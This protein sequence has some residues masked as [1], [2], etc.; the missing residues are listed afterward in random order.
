MREKERVRERERADLTSYPAIDQFTHDQHPRS[1]Q[2]PDTLNNVL[3]QHAG[4]SSKRV[5]LLGSPP[6]PKPATAQQVLENGSTATATDAV[7]NSHAPLSLRQFS[8]LCAQRAQPPAV[9]TSVVS[10]AQA[11]QTEAI[12]VDAAVPPQHTVTEAA[13]PA[14]M[15]VDAAAPQ[16]QQATDVPPTEPMLQAALTETGAALAEA[17]G[18]D[19]TAAPPQTGA[20]PAVSAAELATAAS[21]KPEAAAA[22]A[23]ATNPC[24]L[25]AE[26]I[27]PSNAVHWWCHPQPLSSLQNAGAEAQPPSKH[28]AEA[29][30]PPSSSH[31]TEAAH[32]PTVNQTANEGVSLV[33]DALT[34]GSARWDVGCAR[35]ELLS[36][37]AEGKLATQEWVVNHYR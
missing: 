18:T 1:E 27:N 14:T 26:D 16:Q 13:Q 34:V 25:R 29:A 30:Q 17:I 24:P 20:E 5:R 11:A 33:S 15:D 3:T 35:Q 37:G 32:P 28:A 21:A 7:T 19:A 22:V 10:A 36:M 8:L 9:S 12:N 6:D 2:C 31:A 4:P 23:H